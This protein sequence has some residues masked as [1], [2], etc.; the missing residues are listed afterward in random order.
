VDENGVVTATANGTVT[1]RATAADGT[2]YGE[3]SIT[4]TGQVIPVTAVTVSVENDVP[5]TITVDG[6]TLQ[7]EATIVPANA[8]NT[9]VIWTIT[10]GA[11]FATVDE[12]GV[13]TATAN[14]TVTV[15]ATA[16]DGTVYGEI[17]IT[18]TGQVIPVTAVIVSVE[19]D[20]PATITTDGGTLQLEAAI[21][22]ANATNTGV[23]W[24]I[25]E[26]A[27]F[28]SI[29]ENGTVTATA[30]GTVTVRATA[31][32][33]TV[34]GEITVTITGQ[35]IAVTTVTVTVE[36]D[37]EPTITTQGGTLQLIATVT[38]ADATVTDVTWSITEGA[39]FA[40]VDT[41]GVV[42]A[43]ANGTVTVRAT[44]ADGT[45]YDEIEVTIN[46]TMG[47]GD[48]TALRFSIYPNPTTGM[49]NISANSAVKDVMVYN[50]L[51]QQVLHGNQN[52]VNLQGAEQ[53]VYSVQVQFENGT[54]ISQK[55]VK[56]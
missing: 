35:V 6:G 20:A 13:V 33:G 7:L 3:I 26:G 52:Q 56:N 47:L 41:N 25:T 4:I 53:G 17:T 50:M 55:V 5:A 14:G 42:T 9:D 28:A 38:P 8:T 11:D 46:L 18:V 2:V 43:I 37:A 12:N 40:T 10:E 21:A 51:G 32:D 54:T 45:V 16:A 48:V 44:A 34:Y 1:V 36:N 19:N 23:T 31:A 15:R 29:D 30:N 27:D 22:P 24:T 49:L 39:D